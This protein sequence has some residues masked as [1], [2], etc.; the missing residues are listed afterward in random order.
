MKRYLF[1]FFLFFAFIPGFTKAEQW[2]DP[3]AQLALDMVGSNDQ[4]FLTSEFVQY[5]YEQSK[6]ISLPRYALDQRQIGNEIERSELQPGDVVFFQGTNLMSGIYIN[7]GRFVVVTSD[8]ISE[9]NMETSEYW[10]GA[11]AGAAQF[12]EEDIDDPAAEL[13]LEELGGNDEGWITSEFVQYVYE[14]AK[15]ISLPQSAADQWIQGEDV[16][17]LQSGD[18]VFFQGTHLMSGI[19]INNGRFV[20][21]TSEGISER[22]MI[23][24]DYWSDVYQG[25]KRYNE[26][27]TPPPSENEIVEL[28]RDLIGTP[29]NRKGDSPEE[30]FNSGSFVYYVY[31]NVTGSWLSKRS[32]PQLEAGM[33]ITRDELQPGDL[34]FFENDEQE[35]ITG[36]YSEDD[37]FVIATSSGVQERHL[38]YHNYYAERYIGAARYTDDILEKSNPETYENHDSSVVREAMNYL[39]T[40]YLMTGS[41]LDAFDC[42]FFVQTVFREALDVYL[43][44][45]SYRQWEVGETLLPEGTDIDVIDLDEELQPGDV[46]YFSGTWQEGISHTAIYLGEDYIVHATGEEGQT[47]ISYMSEYWRDHFTGAKRFEDL[48]IQY[49][50]D[51]VY[52]AYQLLGTEYNQGGSTPGEG[53]DT[54][55]FVQYVYDKAWQY[56][57]PRYGRQQWEEGTEVPRDEAEPGDIFFFQGT[58][59]IPAINIGNNQMIVVTASSGVSVIDLT[60]STYWPPRYIGV[61]TYDT[62]VEE[63]EEIQLA[64]QYVGESFDETSTMF[65]KQIFAEASGINLPSDVENLR[66]YGDELHIEEL[67]PGDLMFFSDIEDGTVPVMAGIYTGAGTFITVI[68][69]EIVSRT[70]N[71]GEH[72]INRL[73]EGRTISGS[74]NDS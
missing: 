71:D 59:I 73:I 23:T 55:G 2:N 30:G 66:K 13:A 3:A 63:S 14:K 39:G 7:E 6:S 19:Y 41:T 17:E 12:T 58:S 49:D 50:N 60:T 8:G 38:D 68:N 40:P 22:N 54:G 32:S 29:Y 52:E 33:D 74:E 57:L 16:D 37:Q 48:A 67:Q 20:I 31:K 5:V 51:A 10:S 61:R 15:G 11:Y 64:E 27:D 9:R 53:F 18:V 70:I 36:I 4:E 21:V 62:E 43:P 25:A 72:W 42:S 65:I 1:L 44:R 24:S 28:A 34:I 47:T 26:E 45:I 69:G 35:I 56:D 46:L